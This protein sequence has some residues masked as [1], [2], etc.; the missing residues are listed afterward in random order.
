MFPN[1]TQA[2]IYIAPTY[3]DRLKEAFKDGL[4]LLVKW[5]LLFVLA[6]Y[7][8][9]YS[10]QTRDMAFNGNQAALVIN[11]YIKKGWL[12]KLIN[13]EAPQKQMELVK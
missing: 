3:K 1:Q 9:S 5:G 4:V 6:A 12:P 2:N 13:G 10:L 8:F 11:E 7:T